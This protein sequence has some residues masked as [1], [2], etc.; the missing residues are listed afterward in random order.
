MSEWWDGYAAGRE[1]E[2]RE[3]AQM[4]KPLTPMALFGVIAGLVI[5]RAALPEEWPLPSPSALPGG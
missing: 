5:L 4:T 2:R 3:R 1:A